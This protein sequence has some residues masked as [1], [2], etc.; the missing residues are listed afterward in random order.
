MN[1]LGLGWVESKVSNSGTRLMPVHSQTGTG[2]N[3]S[4]ISTRT[5]RPNADSW[6]SAACTQGGEASAEVWFL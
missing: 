4:S 3:H 1:I 2:S 6:S 5:L